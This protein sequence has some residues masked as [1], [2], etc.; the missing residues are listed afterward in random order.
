MMPAMEAQPSASQYI[1][2]EICINADQALQVFMGK[3][4]SLGAAACCLHA[5]CHHA[6]LF[7]R[8]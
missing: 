4:K 7:L 8:L 1:P 2:T 3:R 6:T 5:A